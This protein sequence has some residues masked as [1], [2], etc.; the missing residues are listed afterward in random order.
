MTRDTAQ[1]ALL[2]K[3]LDILGVV[4]RD[5]TFEALTELVHKFVVRVPFENISKLYY[6][7]HNGLRFIP[8]L[9]QY[10]EG[11]EHY[12]FGGTCYSNNYYL[13][14]LMRFIG[15]DVMLCG[16][17]MSD[18]DV[19]IVNIVK[20]DERE[21]LVD[22]GY[23]AP[24]LEPIPRD[25]DDT[26][27]IRLGNVRYVLNPQDSSGNSRMNL[28]RNGELAHNYTVKPIAREIGFF[29]DIIKDSYCQSSTFMNGVMLARFYPNR[30]VVIRN[31]AV[32]ESEGSNCHKSRLAGKAELPSKIVM[33]FSIPRDI[34]TV[35]LSGIDELRDDLD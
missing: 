15:H 16:A 17:D 4:N 3:F 26:F 25:L 34:V 27:E 12:H 9:K 10:V 6:M 35:A 23:G 19:H 1:S 20:V 28:Y 32:I 2:I 21:Y 7:N 24:F 33:Y 13:N 14:M 31:T 22:A 5:I 8:D 11:V 18:P 30:S 29:T